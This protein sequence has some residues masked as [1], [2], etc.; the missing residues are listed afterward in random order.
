MLEILFGD[1]PLLQMERARRVGNREFASVFPD[2][3]KHLR[4]LRHLTWEE[5]EEILQQQAAAS[6]TIDVAGFNVK[7]SLAAFFGPLVILG[8][9]GVL[10]MYTD[11]LRQEEPESDAVWW[12]LFPQRMA[13]LFTYASVIVLPLSAMFWDSPGWQLHPAAK[14]LWVGL[15][16]LASALLVRLLVKIVELRRVNRHLTVSRNGGAPK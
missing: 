13:V 14:A 16:L 4:Y 6:A 3:S 10:L 7:R 9:A 15:I 5:A 12:A 8:L 11:E 1:T 2:L